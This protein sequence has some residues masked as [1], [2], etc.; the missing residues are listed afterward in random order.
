[1]PEDYADIEAM[2]GKV[3]AAKLDL[4]KAEER[5]KQAGE[6][7]AEIV[8][9]IE[10]EGV[11]PDNIDAEIAQLETKQ[12]EEADKIRAQFAGV[13]EALAAGEP[14]VATGDNVAAA[15]PPDGDLQVPDI[16]VME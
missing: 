4:A 11:A 7:E 10:A 1:M 16:G 2:R 13:D 8:K 15:V 3:D 6:R 14:V 9:E 12:K 5:E